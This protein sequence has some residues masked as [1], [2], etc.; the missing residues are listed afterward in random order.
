MPIRKSFVLLAAALIFAIS[1]LSC[2][3]KQDNDI[4][5]AG[6]PLF[7]LTGRIRDLD[8]GRP[9][10]G[11]IVEIKAL[12]LKAAA[13][14]NGVYAF[15][16]LKVGTRNL[17]VSAPNYASVLLPVTFQY[18][19]RDL[20]QDVSMTK[21][22]GV[23][24]RADLPMENPSGIWWENNQL[25]V[26]SYDDMGGTLYR[27]DESLNVLQISPHLG[28]LKADTCFAG[29]QT[30][31]WKRDTCFFEIDPLDPFEPDS[32]TVDSIFVNCAQRLYGLVRIADYF[33]T[34]DGIGHFYE[35]SGNRNPF[36][37]LSEP[38]FFRIDP[39]TL[40]AVEIVALREAFN[41]T[42][43][44]LIT[45]LAWDGQAIWLS[46]Y[47]LNTLPKIRP[48]TFT[49]QSV[50][51]SPVSAPVGLAWDGKYM[52]LTSTNRLLQLNH[53]ATIRNRYIWAGELGETLDQIAWDGE[54]IWAV[55]TRARQIYKLTIPFK[56]HL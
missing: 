55:R 28:T 50:F 14:S 21:V 3:K 15:S 54:M 51:P 5:G 9:V 38:H 48:E 39:N 26:V 10:R 36:V 6:E 23:A 46:N 7:T 45:D 25:L 42:E 43:L 17:E 18:E 4:T 49:A 16:D 40:E 34:T 33:Y 12:N 20:V 1:N 37:S 11:A 32:I 53:D 31:F 2:F 35:V 22:L 44:S 30:C 27:L 47:F 41:T 13:D 24:R 56:D 19:I 8:N 29:I 52:W